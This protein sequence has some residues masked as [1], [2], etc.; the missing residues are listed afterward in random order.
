MSSMRN[1]RYYKGKSRHMSELATSLRVVLL[2]MT[3]A[4]A[5][6]SFL[7][8]AYL[9]LFT[10]PSSFDNLFA[11]HV[12]L[13][14]G[15]VMV[16]WFVGYGI[17]RKFAPDREHP[18]TIWPCT[19]QSLLLGSGA[20]ITLMLIRH[21]IQVALAIVLISTCIVLFEIVFTWVE[22]RE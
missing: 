16:A 22:A 21:G 20:L 8:L 15:V 14:I 11:F 4:G 5:L 7:M 18:S 19:R 3:F 17:R 1:V 13:G 2:W 10:S 12:I 6:T 9:V